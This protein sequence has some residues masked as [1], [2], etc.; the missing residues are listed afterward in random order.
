MAELGLELAQRGEL[1]QAEL[2]LL[3]LTLQ[4]LC[5]LLQAPPLLNILHSWNF[6][7]KIQT[8]NP[9]P[10]PGRSKLTPKKKEKMEK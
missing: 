8:G 5:L 10:D 4:V 6:F 7:T 3:R 2:A 1:V 9:V